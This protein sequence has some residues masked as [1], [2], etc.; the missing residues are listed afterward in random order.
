MTRIDAD[1]RATFRD[2]DTAFEVAMDLAVDAGETLVVLGPSGSGKTLL[3]EAI[4]GFHRHEGHVTVGGDDVTDAPPEDRGLGLV[5]QNYALFPHLSV[6]ENVAYGT[7]YHDDSGDPDDLLSAFGVAALAER[8]PDT[9]SG[10][11]AQRVALARALAIRPEAFLL[12]EP[13]SSLDVPTRESLR[14]DL[15]DV[16]A[17][18]TAIYV[19]HDR[20]TARMLADRVAVVSDGEVRQAGPVDEVFENPATAF[21]ARFTGANCIPRDALPESVTAALPAGETVVIRPEHVG[22]GGDD[23]TATLVRSTRQ[24]RGYRLTLDVDGARLAAFADAPPGAETV[25]LS[26]PAEHC[27]VPGD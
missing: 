2:G 1:V 11:E 7:R 5:F 23:A 12:D 6:R 8:S 16:L 18:E 14:A 25:G 20:T 21:V 24:E 22:V 26:I 9:L 19:T 13:L 15:L 17:D 10:G 3:L 4:A 27:V